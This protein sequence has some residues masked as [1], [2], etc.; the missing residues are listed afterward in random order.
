M[1]MA[2]RDS[3]TPRQIRAI[4]LK[5]GLTQEQA[6]AKVG[7]ARRTWMYWESPA[8][9]DRPSASALKLIRLLA[10]GTL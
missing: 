1:D 7:V 9:P 6:A 2:T 4:R 8:R 3:L 10:G 5:L